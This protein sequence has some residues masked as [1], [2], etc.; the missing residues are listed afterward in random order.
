MVLCDSFPVS[1]WS[2]RLHCVRVRW[3]S[4]WF[5]R[6][7][8]RCASPQSCHSGL[9]PGERGDYAYEEVCVLDRPIE[10]PWDVLWPWSA[11]K[12]PTPPALTELQTTSLVVNFPMEIRVTCYKLYSDRGS[13]TPNFSWFC[14]FRMTLKINLSMT[15]IWSLYWIVCFV[16]LF[17]TFLLIKGELCFPYF[18]AVRLIFGSKSTLCIIN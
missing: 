12:F 14:L 6:F 1:G 16:L 15:L 7:S 17:A 8:E 2:Q 5:F 9:L 3:R 11:Y 10:N 13:R 18:T 4:L